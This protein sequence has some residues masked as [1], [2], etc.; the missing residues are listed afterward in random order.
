MFIVLYN[1]HLSALSRLFPV[2][3][4][5]VN[6]VKWG[7]IIPLSWLTG[8]RR[9]RS[10][11]NLL[12][13]IEFALCSDSW[14]TKPAERTKNHWGVKHCSGERSY[15]DAFYQVTRQRSRWL[16]GLFSG[17]SMFCC[18]EDTHRQSFYVVSV[19][20]KQKLA[21]CCYKT[22]RYF[23]YVLQLFFLRRKKKR[24]PRKKRKVKKSLL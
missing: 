3:G 20:E 7:G 22:S 6:T 4:W 8:F 18:H 14:T 15:E 1:V 11:L 19:D 24:S 23:I 5:R 12:P 17:I 9:R 2:I 13:L 10:G 21:T 16:F